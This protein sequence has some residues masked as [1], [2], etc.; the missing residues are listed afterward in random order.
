MTEVGKSIMESAYFI[1]KIG[2]QVES[3]LDLIIDNLS[4]SF[5]KIENFFVPVGNWKS[6]TRYDENAWILSDYVHYIGLKSNYKKKVDPEGY[7]SLQI[8]LW[9]DGAK[10][11]GNDEPLIHICWWNDE[12]RI[13]K[14]DNYF[15]SLFGGDEDFELEENVIINW[16]PE[17]EITRDQRWSYSLRLTSIN[18]LDD[19]RNKIVSPVTDLLTKGI[20]ETVPSIAK[21]DG[22]VFYERSSDLPK[23]R[24]QV[25]RKTS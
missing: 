18:N 7:L 9:Q 24:L 5:E 22:I 19:I 10:F 20:K 16:N 15:G 14:D 12:I 23:R 4:K 13:D 17:T 3:M 25:I 8:S 11:D 21:L 6:C 1:A 2:E